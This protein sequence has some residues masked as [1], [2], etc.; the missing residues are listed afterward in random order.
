[1]AKKCLQFQSA[2]VGDKQV[3]IV[4]GVRGV[5]PAFYCH[6]PTLLKLANPLSI[7]EMRCQAHERV[8]V[9]RFNKLEPGSELCACC[10]DYHSRYTIEAIATVLL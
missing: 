8:P 9:S 6:V 3:V 5:L 4:S 2:T 10:L 1:M 7:G